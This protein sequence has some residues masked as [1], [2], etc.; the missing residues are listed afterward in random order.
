MC[1]SISFKTSYTAHNDYGIL[2][3]LTL[4]RTHFNAIK[5]TSNLDFNIQQKLHDKLRL[6]V[7]NCAPI[8]IKTLR[9]CSDAGGGLNVIR[10]SVLPLLC[11][12]LK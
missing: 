8:D 5:L 9:L 11:T 1:F 3:N 2:N 12:Y 7:G 10:P 4:E 6:T